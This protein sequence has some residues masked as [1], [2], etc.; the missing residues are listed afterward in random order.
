MSKQTRKIQALYDEDRECDLHIQQG[1]EAKRRKKEIQ[2][3]LKTLAIDLVKQKKITWTQVTFE[4]WFHNQL[5][6]EFWI[7]CT[8][9]GNDM[10]IW[11]GLS[12][13]NTEDREHFDE[14]KNDYFYYSSPN[15]MDQN[16]PRAELSECQLAFEGDCR[17]ICIDR[18]SF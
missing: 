8:D 16:D 15:Y 10:G 1:K 18:N 12:D 5:E 2:S 4:T 6:C 11:K 14:Y 7:Y 17:V 13:L 9:A 3:E